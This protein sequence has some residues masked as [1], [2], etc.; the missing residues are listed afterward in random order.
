MWATTGSAPCGTG[1]PARRAWRFW[2]PYG[3]KDAVR[4]VI[5]NA[6]A[7]E[8]V[9]LRQVGSR[10]Y[11]TNTLELGWIPSPLPA[12]YS[13]DELRGY[14]EWLDEASYEANGSIGGS[15][16]AE[17]ISD[18]YLTPYEL[19]YGIYLKLDHDFVGR[20]ALEAMTGSTQRRKVTL[21][22][23]AE[24][25]MEV[26]ASAFR[27]GETPAKWID[28]PLSN[29]ASSSFDKVMMA[30]RMVGLSMFNGYSYN[31]RC[32]LSLGVVD[33]DVEEG[34]VLTLIWGEPDGGTDKTATE[35]HRQA[36][37][38]VRVSPTPYAREARE[39]YADSWRTRRRG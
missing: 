19:G 22:W 27:P 11:A 36:E 1:W 32:M 7:E 35:K 26:I 5:L 29:Y 4:E 25:V 21:E 2:G 15:F 8:G 14:R 23:N 31:E 9:D 34:D 38:R 39:N 12:V 28:F 30:D 33:A 13:H 17:D 18:Y 20:S 10:A 16:V 3:Q 37:I 24:D 6:A